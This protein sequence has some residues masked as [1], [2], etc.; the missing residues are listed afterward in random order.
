MTD[1]RLG[2]Q[3]FESADEENRRLREKN[4]KLRRLLAARGISVPLSPHENS[5]L[6][7][8][9]AAMPSQQRDERVRKRIVLLRNLFR[10]REDVYARRWEAADG[11]SGYLPAAVKDWKAMLARMYA[12]RLKGYGAIGYGIREERSPLLSLTAAHK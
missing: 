12:R 10:G 5:R 1:H 8:T 3:Q 2:P 11:R 6:V 7:T 4:A 9:G